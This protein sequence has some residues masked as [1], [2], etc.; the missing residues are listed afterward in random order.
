MSDETVRR[1]ADALTQRREER[2]RALAK[3]KAEGTP[4]SL[5]D[6]IST[7]RSAQARLKEVMQII[8]ERD[9]LLRKAHPEE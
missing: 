3:A 6:A 7:L 1:V 4:Q 5:K 9:D 8:K 2:G